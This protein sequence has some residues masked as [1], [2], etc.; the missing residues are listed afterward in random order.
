MKGLVAI[1]IVAGAGYY[2]YNKYV[3]GPPRV[4]E[5]PVYAEMRMT[6]QAGNREIEAAI[7]VRTSSDSDCSGRGAVSWTEAFEG[8]PSCQVKPVQ[9]KAELPARYAR[10]FDDVPIPSTYLSAQ[11]GIA[12]ER[13][14]RVV[15]FGL[16]DAEGIAFCEMLKGKLAE[17][18]QGQLRCIPPNGG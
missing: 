17:R 8:C 18:Y 16:T 2:F 3:G 1:C 9:C 4:I 14:G 7:F 10:L 12:S 5:N 15:V 13:D 6:V 11:A